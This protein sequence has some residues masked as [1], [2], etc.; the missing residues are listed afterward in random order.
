MY[1]HI[2]INNF[3]GF[4][5]FSM[6]TLGRINLITGVNNVGKTALLEAIFLHGG[7]YNPS[8][9]LS[10]D[11]FRGSGTF[12]F[13]LG[14]TDKTPWD[15]LF[16]DF[17]TGNDIEIKGE[18][19]DGSDRMISLH[20]VR[21]SGELPETGPIIQYGVSSPTGPQHKESLPTSPGSA[22]ML[23]LSYAESPGNKS[24]TSFLILDSSGPKMPLL[25]AAPFQTIFLA[26]RQRVRT[27]E[28]AE[29][30]GKLE[31][32]GLQNMLLDALCVMEPRIK[33]VAVVALGGQPALY[34]DIGLSRML[35]LNYVGDGMSRLASL[36]LAIGTA[37]DGIVLIDEIENGFHH[38]MMPKVWE[39]IG[40]A[41][42]DF[43]TQVFAT[44]HSLECTI[45]AHKA[46]SKGEYYD[47]SV[48]RL[49]REDDDE[50][51]DVTFDK[52][53]LNTALELRMDI[54]GVR[55]WA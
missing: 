8:L 40:K 50:V 38:T 42:R 35:K 36:I 33:R 37:K 53:D 55:R 7:A 54:R 27:E 51:K 39:V 32:E 30:F 29:R 12:G 17:D 21:P 23:K 47:L 20:I 46:F 22:I 2:E 28:D 48:H 4:H 26:A 3:K 25:R 16:N 19:T 15:S 34:G 41:A 44:T 11:V 13:E 5:K 10:I 43:N 24:G 18:F 52:D 31:I 45:S 14:N 49:D 1:K 9:A 6:N